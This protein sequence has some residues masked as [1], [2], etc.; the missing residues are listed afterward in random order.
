MGIEDDGVDN[1]D[2]G[3]VLKELWIALI[4][5]VGNW[6]VPEGILHELKATLVIDIW[7]IANSWRG[8]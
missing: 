3:M 1:F 4:E 5:I 6:K 8:F 2:V 7:G